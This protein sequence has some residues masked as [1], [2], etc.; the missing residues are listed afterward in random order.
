MKVWNFE[1]REM[2][3]WKCPFDMARTGGSDGI[4]RI[5]EL[6]DLDFHGSGAVSPADLVFD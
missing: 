5:W 2:L 3:F 4:A 1:A 6:K